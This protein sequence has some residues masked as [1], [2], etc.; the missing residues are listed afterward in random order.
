M[1]NKKK[2]KQVENE[3]IR[4]I[5]KNVNLP[6]GFKPIV[7]SNVEEYLRSKGDIDTKEFLEIIN[8]Y[9]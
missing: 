9:M 6:N 5:P 3:A 2:K 7:M 8:K 4:N 1:K